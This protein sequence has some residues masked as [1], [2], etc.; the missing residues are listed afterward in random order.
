MCACGNEKKRTCINNAS[1]ITTT[2]PQKTESTIQMRQ[3]SKQTRTPIPTRKSCDNP[4]FVNTDF[5]GNLKQMMENL[6]MKIV[7]DKR[8]RQYT[9]VGGDGSSFKA[10]KAALLSGP[11]KSRLVPHTVEKSRWRE[12][13][14][15]WGIPTSLIRNTTQKVGKLMGKAA[16]S[17]K[18]DKSNG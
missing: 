10:A 18:L 8:V 2:K 5:S 11:L 6:S 13:N 17:E 12:K 16:I 4:V 15:Y 3:T 1:D 7:L 9:K 14:Q